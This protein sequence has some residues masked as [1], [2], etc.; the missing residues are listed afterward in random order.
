MNC[1]LLNL[2]KPPF[3]NVKVRQ[4]AAMAVSSAQYAQVIDQGIAP[5]SNGPFVSGSPYFA[6]TGYPAPDP[7]KA[8]QL[9]QEVQGRPEEPV[10]F[11]LNHTPDPKGSQIGQYLQQQL[12]AAGMQVTL[13]PIQQDSTSSTW[14]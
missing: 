11:T 12:Q 4:A 2:S 7:A 5:T 1:L 8:K 14:P 6:P 9:V 10:A 3:N 13:S